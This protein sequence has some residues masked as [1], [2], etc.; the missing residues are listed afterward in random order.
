MWKGIHKIS[1]IHSIKEIVTLLYDLITPCPSVSDF[2]VVTILDFFQL[3]RIYLIA[4]SLSLWTSIQAQAHTQC[5]ES[6]LRGFILLSHLK[7]P[8]IFSRYR[9]KQ[10]WGN[11]FFPPLFLLPLWRSGS[12]E[13]SLGMVDSKLWDVGSSE[14]KSCSP[15]SWIYRKSSFGSD[16]H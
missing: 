10:E 1:F 5:V 9:R 14:A 4:Q 2:P 11:S 13:Q 8:V 15:K 6:V 3:H 16:R 12:G 7:H